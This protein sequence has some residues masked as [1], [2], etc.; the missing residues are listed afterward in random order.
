MKL[1][2][3]IWR[4]IK[5]KQTKIIIMNKKTLL[6]GLALLGFT[7][8]K[9]QEDSGKKFRFGLKVT[10]SINWLKID[11]EKTYAKG[12]SVMKL[13][14]GLITEF[15]ITEVAS[16]VTGFQVDYDGGRIETTDTIGY[17]YNEDKGFLENESFGN[18]TAS[19]F[20]NINGYTSYMLQKRKYNSMYL[21]IPLQIKL[22]TKEIGYLT[23]FGNIGLL[24]SVHIKTK[25]TDNVTS[26]DA[27]G[28]LVKSEVE[29]L[30]ISKDMN[31]LKAGLAIGAG[32][33]M[34]L[35]GSTSLMFGLQFTQG[36]MNIVKKDSKFNV[37]GEMS[38]ISITPPLIG[39]VAQA[40]KFLG[41]NIALT[42]GIL[43]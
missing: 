35:S 11:D 34:N 15:K 21:T 16:F 5:N 19:Y 3:S 10:P 38:V 17:F 12:G 33:E 14:Y 4:F 36:F 18:D 41:Q 39:M 31:I 24:A 2:Q 30:D 32:V 22:R 8:A 43:F 29:K 26:Y 1:S 40:Q 28:N 9:S 27:A 23:Y 25:A 6:I 7:V 37:D 13:G 42:I 20:S